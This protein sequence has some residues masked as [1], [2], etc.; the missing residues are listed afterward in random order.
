MI[1]FIPTWSTLSV[2]LR[3]HIP[4]RLRKKF[5]RNSHYIRSFCLQCVRPPPPQSVSLASFYSTDI[6][7]TAHSHCLSRS[8]IFTSVPTIPHTVSSRDC[9]DTPQVPLSFSMHISITHINYIIWLCAQSAPHSKDTHQYSVGQPTVHP[10][11]L[12]STGPG[13]FSSASNVAVGKI[14]ML[15][16]ARLGIASGSLKI[17]NRSSTSSA[18]CS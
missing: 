11:A 16:H 5:T 7:A 18:G 9:S 15:Q 2:S 8:T 14:Y 6:I 4:L 12:Y 1:G 10:S 3:H 17:L 13:R